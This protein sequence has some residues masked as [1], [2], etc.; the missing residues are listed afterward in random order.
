[1]VLALSGTTDTLDIFVNN[2]SDVSFFYFEI[3]DTPDL[4]AAQEIIATDRTSSW[5]LDVAEVGG[6]WLY[7]T[8]FR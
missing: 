8:G 4:I 6:K 3:E 7:R 1:V 2:E 5:S